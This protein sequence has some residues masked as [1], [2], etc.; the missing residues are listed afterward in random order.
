MK[1]FKQILTLLIVGAIIYSCSNEIELDSFVNYNQIEQIYQKNG[2]GNTKGNSRLS[3]DDPSNDPIESIE[4]QDVE[5]IESIES[6]NLD[7]SEAMQLLSPHLNNSLT[8][9]YN[10]GFSQAEL[11]NEFGSLDNP[12][13]V[14]AAD[15]LRKI[16]A[17]HPDNNISNRMEPDYYDCLLRA[18]GIDAVIELFNGKVTKE[19]AKK[20]I[21]KV[22]GRTMGWVGAA[23]AVYE[24][25]SCM[26]WY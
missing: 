2:K 23:I 3:E 18:V 22:V 11:I 26:N 20:A 19:I 7:E 10:R 1:L 13:I 24:F 14:A 21:R 12:N 8:F 17:V 9:F 5:I 6:N 16:E 4:Y 15:G 25:G